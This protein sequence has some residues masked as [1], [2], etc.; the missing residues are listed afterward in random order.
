MILIT[1]ITFSVA[2]T[3]CRYYG[4][5]MI[6]SEMAETVCQLHLTEVGHILTRIGWNEPLDLA[7]SYGWAR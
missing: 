6:F 3:V 2:I 5:A 7:A 1:L 4:Y